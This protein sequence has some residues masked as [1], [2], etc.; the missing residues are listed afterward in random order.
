MTA[1][2]ECEDFVDEQN[3]Y[4]FKNIQIVKKFIAENMP[5]VKV[6]EI[7]A[8]Y[9]MWLDFRAWNLPQDELLKL[10]RSW[11]IKLND[12][13][14]YGKSGAGFIR[15]NVATQTAVLQEA[16]ERIKYGYG[17]WKKDGI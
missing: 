17:E 5:E 8:S 2:N 9:L 13:S 10:F 6:T 7:E 4:L 11:G 1:Y 3:E 15:L 12:G 16:L 14:G